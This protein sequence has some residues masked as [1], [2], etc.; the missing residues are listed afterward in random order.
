VNFTLDDVKRALD[1][2]P[3]DISQKSIVSKGLLS[4]AHGQVDYAIHLGWDLQ[5]ANLCDRTWSAF[6]SELMRH[7]RTLELAGTDIGPILDAAQLEDAHWRWLTKSLSYVGDSYKWFFLIAEGYPQAACMIYHPKMSVGDG[8]NIFYVEYLAA[9]PWN[10]ENA[11]K[12]RVFKGVGPLLLNYVVDYAKSTLGLRHGFSLHSLP[13][14]VAFY[15]KIGMTDYPA[16]D[17]ENGQL[18]FF[19]WLG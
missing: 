2:A 8:A 9:A 14:A 19:E 11:M 5:I 16:F 17:K 12:E 7:I 13:K 15:K 18:K 4:G 6:N 1:A 10:R 3:A